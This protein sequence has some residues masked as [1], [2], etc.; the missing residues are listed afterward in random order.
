[1]REKPFGL[2]LVSLVL[3]FNI[4]YLV[5]IWF[6]PN[7]FIL[8]KQAHIPYPAKIWLI[9]LF[10]LCNCGISSKYA[11][12]AFFAWHVLTLYGVW[13]L[14]AWAHRSFVYLLV[15][16]IIWGAL[17]PRIAQSAFDAM[18]PYVGGS[19]EVS[20]LNRMG[21]EAVAWLGEVI[22]L[23]WGLMFTVWFVIVP[24]CSL[25]YLTETRIRVYFGIPIFKDQKHYSRVSIVLYLALIILSALLVLPFVFGL[26]ANVRI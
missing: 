26:L 3:L 12:A 19:I 15:T 25:Y 20:A 6:S 7:T 8:I 14:Q 9:Y 11:L 23:L 21:F 16:M 13:K 2:Q 5:A 17:F 24:A 1:M 10:E 22:F 18:L 4:A